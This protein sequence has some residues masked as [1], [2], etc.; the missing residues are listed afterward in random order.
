M[1]ITAQERK[2][3]PKPFEPTRKTDEGEGPSKPD[4]RQP[5]GSDELLKRLRKID[6]EQAKRYRQRSGQ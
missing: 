2:T 5:G 4:V 1:T 3:V 6:P